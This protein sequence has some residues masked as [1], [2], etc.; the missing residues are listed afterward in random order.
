MGI[1]GCSAVSRAGSSFPLFRRG[2]PGATRARSLSSR[3]SPHRH[4]QAGKST[5]ASALREVLLERAIE[6]RVVACDASYRPLES[7]PTCDLAVEVWGGGPVPDAFTR[8]RGAKLK[9]SLSLSLSLSCRARTHA[10]P[11]GGGLS[12]PRD[13]RRARGNADLNVPGSVDWH[14]VAVTDPRR[15][16][17]REREREMRARKDTSR[18]GGGRERKR[19]V[20]RG[21]SGVSISSRHVG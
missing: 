15:F 19:V 11:G 14:A 20:Q 1:V 12:F 3:E 8:A 9:L 10:P 18:K 6:S 5:V 13:A 2:S 4:E 21:P 7:C 17:E 16:R